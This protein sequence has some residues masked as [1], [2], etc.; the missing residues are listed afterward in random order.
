MEE[1]PVGAAVD[2]AAHVQPLDEDGA[3]EARRV[4]GAVDEDAGAVVGG[5][6]HLRHAVA[7][8]LVRVGAAGDEVLGLR[9]VVLG[10]AGGDAPDERSVPPLIG[11]FDARQLMVEALHRLRSLGEGTSAAVRLGDAHAHPRSTL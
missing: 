2:A 3:V 8:E 11:P 4:G 5:V 7:P 6:D 9:V 1:R 10:E